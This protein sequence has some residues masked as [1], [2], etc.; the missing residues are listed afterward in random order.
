MEIDQEENRKTATLA[1]G[2]RI[3]VRYDDNGEICDI[4]ISHDLTPSKMK[5]GS[6]VDCMDICYTKE[7]ALFDTDKNNGVYEGAIDKG[8]DFEKLKVLAEKIFGK[9]EAA[10]E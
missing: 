5:D 10:E 2:R 1:D 6:E 3:S 8:Y 4:R 7:K 9:W